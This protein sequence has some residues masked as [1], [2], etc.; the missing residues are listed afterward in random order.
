MTIL[1][2]KEDWYSSKSCEYIK[3]F[4]YI[5]FSFKIQVRKIRCPW[6]PL[7]YYLL[8]THS[9]ICNFI[10]FFFIE[11]LL[12]RIFQKCKT[13]YFF[14]E[15]LCIMVGLKALNGSLCPR[16][17]IAKSNSEST[18]LPSEEHLKDFPGK[19]KISKCK[20][21]C[22]VISINNCIMCTNFII[23]KHKVTTINV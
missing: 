3:H 21:F 7:W 19:R 1:N 22:L 10:I 15:K 20:D 12:S 9:M 2:L 4:N 11:T 23:K 6:C 13:H 17:W 8:V 16:K 18:V 5:L 14:S